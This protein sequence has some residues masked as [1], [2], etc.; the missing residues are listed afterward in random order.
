MTTDRYIGE[1][2][3]GRI[4]SVKDAYPERFNTLPKELSN[5]D[6]FES[7]HVIVGSEKKVKI[8]AVRE[9][10]EKNPR[11][12]G[13]SIAYSGMKTDSKIA[14]QP[15][16]IEN[17][18]LGCMNR[19]S[20]VADAL[21]RKEN[22]GP[23]TFICAV[24]NYFEENGEFCPRDHAYVVICDPN[25]NFFEA[26]SVG[27]QIDRQVFEMA[28]NNIPKNSTG[29][30]KTIG[31]FLEQRYGFNGSDWFQSVLGNEPHLDRKDQILT[32]LADGAWF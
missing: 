20:D 31:S 32:T 6:E 9:L 13:K 25:Q 24:E 14:E 21:P 5:Y 2:G 10:F 26:V 3:P 22:P 23:T 28:T 8:D 4:I 7:I 27:V 17:G 19:I 15:I 12:Q 18:R 29:Y 30:S 11:F 1:Y 16:G